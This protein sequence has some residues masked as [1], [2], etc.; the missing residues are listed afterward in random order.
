MA[1]VA[2]TSKF[3]KFARPVLAWCVGLFVFFPIFLDGFN[4]L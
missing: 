3:V 2:Q 4:E 1:I